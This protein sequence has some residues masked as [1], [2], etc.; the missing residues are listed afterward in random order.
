MAVI[1]SFNPCPDAALVID[2]CYIGIDRAVNFRV[3]GSGAIIESVTLLQ[4]RNA[5]P[6]IV[7]IAIRETV[8]GTDT[9][10]KVTGDDLS[11]VTSD[12]DTLPQGARPFCT[13]LEWRVYPLLTPLTVTGGRYYSIIITAPNAA[14]G[15][16]LFQTLYNTYK[17][18]G[19]A[20]GKRWS[21]NGSWAQDGDNSGLFVVYGKV[22]G[23]GAPPTT[24]GKIWVVGTLLKYGDGEGWE[25]YEEGF[26]VSS[27]GTAR[28]LRYTSDT[29]TYDDDGA[30]VREILGEDTG[31]DGTI[32]KLSYE[33]DGKFL[34]SVDGSGKKKQ[35]EGM[36]S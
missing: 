24:P 5:S 15:A 22:W 18:A 19:G 31:S 35:I 4:G 23:A 16:P 27:G 29:L 11:V 2:G 3:P 1:A 7:Q 10:P 12:G 30:L 33:V 6:G 20:D 28:R 9:S 36:L 17:S 21:G 25:R 13:I 14:G 8:D 34:D 26:L 32:G